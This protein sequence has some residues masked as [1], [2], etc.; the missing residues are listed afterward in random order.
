M[1][2][3][4]ISAPSVQAGAASLS[5]RC[6]RNSLAAFVGAGEKKEPRIKAE[7]TGELTLGF[8]EHYCTC[9]WELIFLF[10]PPPS[11]SCQLYSVVSTGGVYVRLCGGC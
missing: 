9:G 8:K 3:F 11:R 5:G 4:V 7:K 2:N 10:F 6:V 1:D